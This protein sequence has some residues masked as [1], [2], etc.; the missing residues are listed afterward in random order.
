MRKTAFYL[1]ASLLAPAAQAYSVLTHEAIIDTAWE[2]GIKP[3]LLKRFPQASPDDLLKAHAF[4]YGGC[5]IQDMGYYPFGSRFFSD[6]T[7]Y[8]RSGDFVVNLIRDAQDL[9]EYAFALGALAHYAADNEGHPL[10]VNPAVPLE[11][12]KMRR[13]YGA[14]ATYEDDPTDHIRVEFG[15][16]VLQVARG[17]YAP[18]AYHDF[19]GF[20]VSKPL[21]ERA[22]GDTYSLEVKDVFKNLDLALGTYRHAVSGVIPAMT[23]AAWSTRKDELVKEQ[24]G[25]TRRQFTYNL[26][27]ASY[28]KEWDRTYEQPGVGARVLGFFLRILP[29]VGPLKALKFK[30]PTPQA[31]S[32]F[33]ESFDQ[34]MALYT[35]LLAETGGGQLQLVNRN[36]DTGQPIQ[37]A[38]YR[39]ADDAFAKL[40][41]KLAEKEPAEVGSQVRQDIL[42]Y[43][44]D[45]ELPFGTKKDP[46][47]WQKTLAAVNKLKGEAAAT[48]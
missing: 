39:M 8:V 16:D 33:E 46:K 40:A 22:F 41:E 32:Y 18:K 23:K 10:G 30:A 15:F 36:F 14:L 1:A 28:R 45:P 27:K 19:I 13:K 6:L 24:P 37:P 42:A 4:A 25:L 21:L 2:P 5:I 12:P 35:K 3:L 31:E 43:F 9:D 17:R 47:E 48:Q 7:H 20:E 38:K 26:S 34:T 44:N 29:K 11:Y